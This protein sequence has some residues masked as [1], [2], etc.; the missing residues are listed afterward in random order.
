MFTLAAVAQGSTLLSAGFALAAGVDGTWTGT[1]ATREG[2]FVQVF[3][4]KT[5][6]TTL[7]GTVKT[8]DGPHVAISEGRVEGTRVSFTLT[9]DSGGR[10]RTL[11]YSGVVSGD[12]IAFEVKL[13]GDDPKAFTETVHRQ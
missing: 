6:G 2:D 5:E 9:V 8:A 3:K 1:L 7:S 4:L 10:S 12:R 11:R 13:A